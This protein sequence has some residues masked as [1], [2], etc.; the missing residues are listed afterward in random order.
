M[1]QYYPRLF[2]DHR[3]VWRE[4]KPGQPFGIGWDEIVGVGGHKVDGITEVYTVIELDFENG[5]WLELH[6]DLPGFPEVVQAIAARLTGIAPGWLGEVERLK[7]RQAAITVWR[8][9]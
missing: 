2:A 6:A 7:P 8:R 5:E 3:G 9:A 4:D 1:S